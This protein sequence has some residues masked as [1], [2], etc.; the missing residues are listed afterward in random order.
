MRNTA[1]IVLMLLAAQVFGASEIEIGVKGGLE[2]AL[3]GSEV[4]PVFDVMGLLDI[5]YA[6]YG[7]VDPCQIGFQTGIGIGYGMTRT[8][9][10]LHEQF[11]NTDYLGNEMDYSVRTKINSH[12]RQAQM[13][14][15]LLFALR[16]YGVFINVGPRLMMPIGGTSSSDIEALD[17]VAYYP[18]YDVSVRNALVTGRS[19]PTPYAVE[20]DNTDLPKLNI[21]CGIEVGY[22]WFFRRGSVGICAFADI[23]VWHTEKDVKRQLVEVGAINN[24]SYPVAPVNVLPLSSVLPEQRYVAFG[25]RLHYAFCFGKQMTNSYRRT[26]NS[27]SGLHR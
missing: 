13:E 7:D 19:Q 22:D 26:Y 12:S 24:P 2:T 14:V 18:K 11:T 15:P 6:Y 21:L 20:Y 27:R 1:V 3:T 4:K 5:R 10:I 16:F 17:I 9:G 23:A 8:Q 25:L